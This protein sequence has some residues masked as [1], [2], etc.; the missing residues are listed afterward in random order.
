MKEEKLNNG[1]IKLSAEKG[2]VDTRINVTYSE[3]ICAEADVK[4]FKANE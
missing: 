1:M 4:Y 2:V 3:V